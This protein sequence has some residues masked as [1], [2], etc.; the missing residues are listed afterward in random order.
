M[1]R[2]IPISAIA[3]EL[4]CRHVTWGNVME[5]LEVR[6]TL[7]VFWVIFRDLAEYDNHLI[8]EIKFAQVFGCQHI[9]CY[10]DQNGRNAESL[11]KRK[12]ERTVDME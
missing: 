5:P 8:L 12:P 9:P 3:I 6:W 10:Y 11:V 1:Q 7:N 2:E 4:G